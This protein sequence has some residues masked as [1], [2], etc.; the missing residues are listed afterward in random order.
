[1]SSGTPAVEY[2]ESLAVVLCQ[3]TV[4]TYTQREE[5][6]SSIGAL[7]MYK[8]KRVIEFIENNLAENITFREMAAQVHASFA[9]AFKL[10]AGTTPNRFLTEER[11][12]AAMKRLAQTDETIAAIALQLGFRSQS[13]FT[14]VFRKYVGVTPKAYRGP[15]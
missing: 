11:M 4:G 6:V 10:T 9:R 2:L 1:M 15:R 5:A 3:D 7:P 12:Q 14:E 8:L 13:H